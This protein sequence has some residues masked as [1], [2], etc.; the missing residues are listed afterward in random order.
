[1][2]FREAQEKAEQLRTEIG[3]HDFLYYQK[4]K[5]EI[6]DEE[7]DALVKELEALEA[8]FPE[9]VTPD[10]PTQRVG[11]DLTEDFPTVEHRVPML[12]ISNTYDAG[13]LR[14]FD[15]RVKR[16]LGLETSEEVEYLVELKIDGVAV[17][18]VYEDGKLVRGVT[19]GDGRKGDEIT[20]NIRTIEAIPT[21]LKKDVPGTLEARGE[22]YFERGDFERMNEEREKAGQPRFANPRN[23]AAGTLKLLDP[24]IVSERPLTISLHGIGYTDRRDLPGTHKGLLEFY[25]A[26][27]LRVNPHSTVARGIDEIMKRIDEWER[28]R[29]D[30]EYETDGLVVKVNRRDWQ[31]DLGAT[32]KSPRWVVAYK[33]SAEQAETELVDV[34]WQVGR[35]GRVTPVA[36]LNPV[37]LAGT[38]VKRASLHNNFFL[39]K[40]DLRHGDHV[41]IEKGGEIIP[42][43]VEVVKDKRGKRPVEAPEKCPSC[44][45]RL[46]HEAGKDSVTGEEAEEMHLLCIDASCPAQVREKIRHFASR[47]AMD[48]EGLGEKNVNLLVDEGLINNI[49]D[50]YRLSVDDLLPLERFAKKSAENLVNAIEQSKSQTLGRFLF[51]LGIPYIGA[52]TASDLA[53]HFGTLEKFRKASYEELLAMEGIGEKV[54]EAIRDF[55]A[56]EENQKLVDELLSLGV[57]PEPDATAAEREAHRS[58]AFDGKTFVLTGEMDALTRSEAKAEIEK[59]GGRTTGSVSKKTDVVVVGEN[60]G[61][62]YKKAQELGVA[63]WNEKQLLE[64]LGI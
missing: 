4:A 7:Y 59:R 3:H 1:M 30:L 15:E 8:E 32:S 60:P 39:K 61:S 36:N 64:E 19:R 21:K 27:G 51:G 22:I 44:G 13:E 11:A 49:A 56:E 9:L 16:G 63:T 43:V 46:V 5:P 40:M 29:H 53:A 26:V 62:K 50:L 37:F 14:D 35:T 10:S 18:L 52:T 58:E 45:S 25:E 57:A 48:I 6:S 24:K 20:R 33:F 28:R 12:S 54:A 17:A 23:A 47:N 42:K 34:S 31:E 2:D 38:T 55:W 41:I